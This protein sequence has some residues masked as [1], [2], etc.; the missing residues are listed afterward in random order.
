MI[1]ERLTYANVVSTLCLFG[2]LA[3]GTAYAADTV[4]STDIVDGQVKTVDLA[5]GAVAVA[6]LADGSITGD[7]IKDESDPG[8]RRARQ[9]RSRAPT[10]TSR[11][12]PTSAAAGRPV[13]T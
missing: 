3:G 6:K 9:Q 7:K 13:A 8:P 1:R 2:L 11:R 10:S 4:F 5:N 12:S